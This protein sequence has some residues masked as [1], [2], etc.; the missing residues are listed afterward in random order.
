MNHLSPRRLSL[1][2]QWELV[3]FLEGSRFAGSP[4]ELKALGLPAI[5]ATV[6]GNVEL[7]MVRAGELPEPFFGMNTTLLRPLEF[8]EWWYRREFASPD[9]GAAELVFEGL[10]CFATVWLN[11]QL[12]GTSANAMIAHRFDASLALAA[13]GKTNELVV[14]LASPVNAVRDCPIGP[15]DRAQ[16]CNGD[17]L[18]ARKPPHAYG[19]DIM[20]RALSAGI[21][22]PV[23]LEERR[24]TDWTNLFLRTFR[25]GEQRAELEL[26]FAFRT[27]EPML[28]GFSLQIEGACGDSTFRHTQRLFFSAGHIRFGVNKPRLWWPRGYGEAA[29]YDVTV[30][31]LHNGEAVAARTLK[32]GIRTVELDRTDVNTREKPGHFF[33]KVNG[34]RIFCKGSNWVP[35]DAFH[36]RD[37]ERIP[38]LLALFADMECNMLRC[39]GGNVYEPHLFYDICD[40]E[41]ILVW[42]DFAMACASYPQTPD[43]QEMLREEAEWVVC[44]LRNHPSIALWAGDNECDCGYLGWWGKRVDPATNVLTRQVLPE[45]ANRLDPSRPYLPSSPYIAS[46]VFALGGN[47]E[48]APEQHLWGPRDYYKSDFYAK[49]TACFASE[50][51]YHGCPN[52]SSLAKFI[53]PAKLWPARNNDEWLLHST[54]PM[55]GVSNITYRIELMHK[56][57]LEVFGEIPDTLE[58]FAFASQIIQGEAKKFF[59]EIFRQHKWRKSGVLWWNMVDGWPQISDAIVDYYF[60]KKLAYHYLKRVHGQLAVIVREPGAWNASVVVSNDSRQARQGTYRIWDADTD[61][62]VLAG[63][64]RVPAN[65]NAELGT[66]RTPCSA[67]RLFLI[68]WESDG[69]KGCSHYLLGTPPF[70]LADYRRRLPKIAALDHSFDPGRVGK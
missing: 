21:W 16:S 41:G 27:G 7:D 43:F 8:H 20:P 3:H 45:V 53:S 36:S 46:E 59:L 19:W 51:G 63:E 12:L 15:A 56:Q 70:S 32:T 69:R 13:P 30:T 68:E 65:E 42:Q 10:D 18:W 2:G 40:R 31:L 66:I 11:G 24:A 52:A 6:P 48:L 28:D 49:N 64:F 47:L 17:S 23:R 55:P 29:L 34:E 44:E 57:V 9:Y 61:E 35:A 38:D 14:R 33:F 50:M 22:R 4:K 37:A 54:D 25:A 5:A 67:Q 39:W 58:E 26:D 1:D 62:T 60:G